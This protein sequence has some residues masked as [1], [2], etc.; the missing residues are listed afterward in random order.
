MTTESILNRVGQV[1]VI[2]ILR[3][4]PDA[5]IEPAVDAL[6]QGGIEAIEVTLDAASA[7]RTLAWL[8]KQFGDKLLIGAG[9]ILTSEDVAAAVDAGAQY[10]LSPHLDVTLLERAAELGYPMV[11][12]VLTPSEIMTAKLHGAKVLK[13]FPA[14]S[15]GSAYMK[16]LL[17]PFHGTAF[18]P[19]GGINGDNAAEFVRAGAFALGIGSSLV[20]RDDIE[21]AAW[22]NV[23]T[24][25]QQMVQL[26]ADVRGHADVAKL[27]IGPIESQSQ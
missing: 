3:R 26:V 6:L 18:I 4:L 27:R 13:L 22:S 8:R 24:K 15:H 11:P 1:G 14:G 2:A 9:T 5:A 25:A 23:R 19:T 7:L 10:L 21:N 12:G 20:T 17:G 16:D